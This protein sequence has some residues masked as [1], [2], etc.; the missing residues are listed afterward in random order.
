MVLALD[1][2]RTGLP[3]ASQPDRPAAGQIVADLADGPDRVVQREVA[4]RHPGLDHLQNQGCGPDLEHRRRLA[5]VGVPDDHVQAPVFLGVGVR[6]VA[7]IDDWT[8]P[9]GGAGDV[10]CPAG[11]YFTIGITLYKLV[12]EFELNYHVRN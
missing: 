9:G 12:K 7:G 3:A 6:F 1:I 10:P 4:E 2:Q 11:G 8:R 5:H